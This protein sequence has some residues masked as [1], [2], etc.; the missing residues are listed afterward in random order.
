M[1]TSVSATSKSTARINHKNKSPLPLSCITED[2]TLKRQRQH[3]VSFYP[4]KVTLN[5]NEETVIQKS[6]LSFVCWFPIWG[7]RS[8]AR[9]FP[10]LRF[11]ISFFS[12][13]SVEWS[14]VDSRGFPTPR[15]LGHS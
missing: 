15:F 13:S 8:I 2:N 1:V 12:Q 5:I 9:S 14:M 11:L 6:F 10:S 7:E 4:M 3:V